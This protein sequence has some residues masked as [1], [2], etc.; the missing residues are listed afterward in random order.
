MSI[1]ENKLYAKYKTINYIIFVILF[2]KKLMKL[3]SLI[4]T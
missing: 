2:S 3:H 4:D 1:I